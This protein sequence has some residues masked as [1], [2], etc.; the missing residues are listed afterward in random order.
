LHQGEIVSINESEKIFKLTKKQ[1]TVLTLLAQG[2]TAKQCADKL[3]LSSRTI[4]SHKYRMLDI[5][6]L[7]K[8]SKLIQ[9]A[10]RNGLGISED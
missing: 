1:R 9:F 2:N 3:N 5:L 7:D 10:L 4:E 6:N 8:H